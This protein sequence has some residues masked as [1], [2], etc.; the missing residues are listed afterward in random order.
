[1][2]LIEAPTSLEAVTCA[3]GENPL[4]CSENERFVSD[5]PSVM[6]RTKHVY[7]S[8]C[9]LLLRAVVVNDLQ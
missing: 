1:M 7:I 6:S 9:Y 5:N 2:E 4:L 8:R 3:L